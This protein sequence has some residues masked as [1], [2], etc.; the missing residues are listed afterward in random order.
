MHSD[1]GSAVFSQKTFTWKSHI[2]IIYFPYFYFS[3][4]QIAYGYPPFVGEPLL[5]KHE[6]FADSIVWYIYRMV[7]LVYELKVLLD[8]YCVDTTLWLYDS[9]K[10]EDIRQTLFLVGCALTTM[11]ARIYEIEDRGKSEN[12]C[13]AFYHLLGSYLSCLRHFS[14]LVLLPFL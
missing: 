6:S 5:L 9:I 3:S 10:F 11:N 4:M 14:Y 2:T 13:L 1:I 12:F 7:P 8:W